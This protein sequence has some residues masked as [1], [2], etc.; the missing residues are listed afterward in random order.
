MLMSRFLTGTVIGVSHSLI[1]VRA[2]HLYSPARNPHMSLA[3]LL[4]RR[5][6]PR[7]QVAPHLA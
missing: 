1:G 2:A 7:M 5:T 3:Y 4:A 6:R